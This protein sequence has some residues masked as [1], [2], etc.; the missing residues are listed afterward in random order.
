MALSEQEAG[1]LQLTVNSLN[2]GKYECN[3]QTSGIHE[4]LSER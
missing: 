2:L 4:T 1:E 3:N